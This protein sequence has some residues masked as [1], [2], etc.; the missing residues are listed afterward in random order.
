MPPKNT[1]PPLDL[2]C[3]PQAQVSRNKTTELQRHLQTA[4][5]PNIKPTYRLRVDEQTTPSKT[6]TRDVV[7][8]GE[9]HFRLVATLTPF[10]RRSLPQHYSFYCLDLARRKGRT[11]ISI[12]PT[13]S[14]RRTHTRSE[15]KVTTCVCLRFR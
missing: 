12:G 6:H 11:V 13:T 1:S 7:L 9:S 10:K 8:W 2:K 14:E 5:I 3:S 15:K 4:A